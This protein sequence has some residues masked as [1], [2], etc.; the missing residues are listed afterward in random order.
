MRNTISCVAYNTTLIFIL[1][2]SGSLAFFSTL[3]LQDHIFAIGAVISAFFT[4]KT[5][6]AKRKEE[7]E[8]L[9]EEHHRTQLLVYYLNGS[10]YQDAYR[11]TLN[12][13]VNFCF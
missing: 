4:V 9:E 3:S 10:V 12:I 11:W 8:H 2:T 6:Y 1:T 7:R 5:Y 13:S